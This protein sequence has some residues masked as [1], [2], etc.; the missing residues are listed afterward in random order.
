MSILAMLEFGKIIKVIENVYCSSIISD[1]YHMHFVKQA[2]FYKI[3][4]ITNNGKIT[5]KNKHGEI[6]YLHAKDRYRPIINVY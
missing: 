4:S 2:Q 5:A 1:N 3:I 6:I